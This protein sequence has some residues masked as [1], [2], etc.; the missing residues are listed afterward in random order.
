MKREIVTNTLVL[1]QKS[2]TFDTSKET[3][4]INDLWDS[5]PENALGLSAPQIGIHERVFVARLST[6]EY[7]FINPDVISINK[8]NF[9]ST[10]GCLSIP[11]VVRNVS[12]SPHVLV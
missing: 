3:E 9:P 5:L 11:G 7:L 2:A 6:G 10:E 1:C 12:R 4:T 8:N